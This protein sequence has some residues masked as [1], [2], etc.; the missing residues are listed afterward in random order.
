MC[1]ELYI[2]FSQ[3]LGRTLAQ[4]NDLVRQNHGLHLDLAEKQRPTHVCG[5]VRC[6]FCYSGLD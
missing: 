2:V 6:V 3:D 5:L 4:E 1:S